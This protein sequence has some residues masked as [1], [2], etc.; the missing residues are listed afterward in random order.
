[1]RGKR[2][3]IARVMTSILC[4]CMLVLMIS[5]QAAAFGDGNSYDGGGWD[6]GSDWGSD[7]SSDYSSSS[8]Y[9][10][11][12]SIGAVTPGVTVFVIAIIVLVVILSSRKK[13][14]G[15]SAPTNVPPP[16]YNAVHQA[17]PNRTDEI[18]SIIRKQD[19]MFTAPD[20]I[21]FSRQV[22]LDIQAA[23][24]ARDLTPVRGVLHQNLYQQTEQQINQKIQQGI[25]NHLERINISETYLTSYRRDRE[26]EY[27]TVYLAANMIDYQVQEATGQIV[28]GNRT[29]RWNLFY[30]MRFM[31]AAG[32]VT[33]S[34]EEK[35]KGFTCPNCGAPI[36]GTSFGVCEYC[37]STVTTGNYDWVL[38]EF[39]TARRENTTDEG[40]QILDR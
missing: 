29:T 36:K 28:Y 16:N 11:D 19:P 24:E 27:V 7:Y 39:N 9:Y 1:M 2:S 26:Y 4:V 10:G 3:G 17:I 23:W 12:G 18:A 25:V 40:I 31:R 22:Y 30:K 37:D 6:S 32:A 21:A 13:N 35:A 20:F 33:R 34:A 38:S 15:S 8:D 5:I 14:G